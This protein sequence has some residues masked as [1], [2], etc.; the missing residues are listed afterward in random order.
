MS[1]NN[2]MA[3][4]VAERWIYG[5]IIVLT[6]K[7]VDKGYITSDMAAYIAGGGVAAVGGIY[8]WWKN[9]P[10]ALMNRAASQIPS[11]ATLVVAV[12]V[13]ASAQDKDAAQELA[14]SAGEKVVA[15]I[16]P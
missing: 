2:E 15:K 10:G 13:T 12:P 6:S 9:R 7:F 1:N 5:G 4:G 16:Q 14:A 3:K 8:A 11:N